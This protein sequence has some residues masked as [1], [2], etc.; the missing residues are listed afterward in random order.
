MDKN[1]D[2]EA[3]SEDKL[4]TKYKRDE[5]E[6]PD[7]ERNRFKKNRRQTGKTKTTLKANQKSKITLIG[8]ATP[9]KKII[10]IEVGDE[11]PQNQGS[12]KSHDVNYHVL[13][14]ISIVIKTKELNSIVKD[15]GK[16][17]VT[18]SIFLTLHNLEQKTRE[19][20]P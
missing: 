5:A 13:V 4:I 11:R 20:Y 18:S 6:Q 15:P 7:V 2:L 1:L 17:K 12:K 16:K 9:L 14:P 8:W 3:V 19:T 10:T